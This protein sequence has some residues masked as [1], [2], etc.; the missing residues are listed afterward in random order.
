M[1]EA[2]LIAGTAKHAQVA[3]ALLHDIRSGKYPVGSQ[4]P[5]EPELTLALGVSRQTIR[6]ALRHLRE[7]GLVQGEQG[8]GSFVLSTRPV[9]RHGHSFD[10]MD[11]LL[12]YAAHTSLKLLSRDEQVLDAEQAKWLGRKEGESWWRVHTLRMA[13][14][15][16]PPLASSVIMLPY[17]YG[18]AVD[19]LEESRSPLFMLIERGMGETITEIRQEIF[20]TLLDETHA[21]ALALSVGD[22]ALCIERR[23]FGRTGNLFELSRTLHPADA[24]RYTMRLRTN[25]SRP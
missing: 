22:A 11:D 21:R 23:Y 9:P 1:S 25:L 20:A 6:A 3:R 12:Q 7:L 24:F 4:L 17:V 16:G 13:S 10:S 15:D 8:V 14:E 2:L 18:P 5:S 19:E